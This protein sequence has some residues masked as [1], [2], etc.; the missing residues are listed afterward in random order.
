MI[1][2]IFLFPEWT[3]ISL[4]FLYTLLTGNMDQRILT[5]LLARFLILLGH[6]LTVVLLIRLNLVILVG[7]NMLQQIV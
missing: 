7:L 4:L 2:L 5:A 6:Q 3:F 1:L